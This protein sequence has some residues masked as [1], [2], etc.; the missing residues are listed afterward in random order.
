MKRALIVYSQISGRNNRYKV[1]HWLKRY[2]SRKKYLLDFKNYE[3]FV[4]DSELADKFPYDLVV[5]AGGDG[6]IRT[7]ATFLIKNRIN[8]PIAIVPTGS[9][10]LLA[11]G[12]GIPRR[13]KS[14]I[15]AI[16]RSKPLA[17]DVGCINKN[18]YF[19]D[20][21]T[22]G[23]IADR[24]LGADRKWKDY[25]GFWGYV[26]SFF[27]NRRLP[28]YTF[29]FTVDGQE[30]CH[31]GNS[32]FIVNTNKIYGFISRRPINLCD[33]KFE[34]TIATNK[35]FWGFFQALYYYYFH[36]KPPKHLVISQGAKYSI[37]LDVPINAQIDG[38]YMEYPAGAKTIEIEVLPK[39]LTVLKPRD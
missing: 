9:A 21:F 35:H 2:L 18:C 1:N 39:R 4:S 17:I 36:Q 10:N 26:L 6:T 23:Y 12:L 7:V 31:E 34:L 3:N 19:L 11:H 38:D 25:F 16:L 37:Q 20:A 15:R 32:L 5:V 27:F 22:I 28:H 14:A 29:R 30:Y 13:P 8:V 33:G 24:I